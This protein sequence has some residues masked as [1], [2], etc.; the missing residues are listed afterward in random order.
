VSK[1]AATSSL[2]VVVVGC[3]GAK[4]TFGIGDV[5][6]SNSPVAS[7]LIGCVGA[8]ITVGIGDG[9]FSNSLV[10]SS[11]IGCVGAE[12]I[13]GIGDGVLLLSNTL[14]T[15]S[16]CDPL[17]EPITK[18]SEDT[19]LILI[20]QNKTKIEKYLTKVIV[21]EIFLDFG[22]GNKKWIEKDTH[23]CNT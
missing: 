12:I 19:Y 2:I 22:M 11:L 4:I 3:V 17:L 8:K 23:S 18:S 16:N 14:V 5:V 9:V 13:V 15:S 6:F 10:A 1:S 7:S 21:L 20:P